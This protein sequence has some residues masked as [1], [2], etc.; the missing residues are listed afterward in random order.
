MKSIL[1]ANLRATGKWR[2]EQSNHRLNH[3]NTK[4]KVSVKKQS[5]DYIIK[6][7]N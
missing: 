5:F 6:I 1:F 3:M 7:Y 4:I 2:L